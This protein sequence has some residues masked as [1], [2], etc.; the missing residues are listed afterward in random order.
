MIQPKVCTLLSFLLLWRLPSFQVGAVKQSVQ[1]RALKHE[2][3]GILSSFDEAWEDTAKVSKTTVETRCRKPSRRRLQKSSGSKSSSS[4]SSLSSSSLSSSS[5][6]SGSSKS[7]KGPKG[8]NDEAELRDPDSKAKGK[9]SKSKAKGKG[10]KSKK[11][12]VPYCDDLNRVTQSPTPVPNNSQDL[13]T[14]SAPAPSP[15]PAGS[16]VK[17]C[18][19]IAAG[20]ARMDGSNKS[21]DVS[22]DLIVDGS[23]DIQT[24]LTKLEQILQQQVAPALAGCLANTRRRRLQES[25]DTNIV[26]VVFGT[27][28]ISDGK[29]ILCVCVVD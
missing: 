25:D 2:T 6:S 29:N 8:S 23:V 22:A 1:S 3:G 14:N 21:F 15:T 20:T 19:A 7:G 17:D 18:S 24:I 5:S 27:P 26:N 9:G 11:G 4:K 28:A 12:D 13:P 16:N 10:S